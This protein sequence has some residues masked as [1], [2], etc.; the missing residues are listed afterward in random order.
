MKA[1]FNSIV[2]AAYVRVNCLIEVIVIVNLTNY[3]M[4]LIAFA[5]TLVVLL[6]L[7][8]KWALS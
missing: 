3:L 8:F 5:T 7:A 1:T 2:K 4:F 6:D